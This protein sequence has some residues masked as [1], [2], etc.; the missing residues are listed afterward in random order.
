MGKPFANE[1]KQIPRSLKWAGEIDIS[2][3]AKFI[4]QAL[5]HPLIAIGAGG[6]FTIAEFTRLLHEERGGIGL[7]F[8]P[9]SFIQSK[10]DIRSGCVIIFTASGNNRDV[11][12]TYEA[13]VKREPQSILIVCGKKQ[14]KVEAKAQYHE[15][16]TVFAHTLPA[17]RDGYLATNSLMAFSVLVLRAFGYPAP[18]MEQVLNHGDNTWQQ[19]TINTLPAVPSY[20]LALFGDWGR[21]AATDFE[22]KF[23]EAGLGGVMLADY[24]HFAHGRHNW[25]DKRGDQSTIV[26]FLT[27][28]TDDLAKRTL[29]L[30]PA[31]TRII[32]L[33][34]QISGPIATLVLLLEI[35]RFTLQVGQNMGIDPGRP[36]VPSYGSKIYHLG[37]NPRLKRAASNI[38]SSAID[39]KLAVRGTIRNQTDEIAVSKA[40][41]SYI[42]K[43]AAVRFGALVADFDGTVVPPGI[44]LGRQ[45]SDSVV[46]FFEKLLCT[47]AQLY[48]ATGRGDSIHSIV[49]DSIN[50][51]YHS[52]IYIS[53][54]NGS[55][56]ASLT[57][58]P[59]KA[60]GGPHHHEFEMLLRQFRR[61]PLLADITSIENKS[62]QL[63]VRS[64]AQT[65]SSTISTIIRELVMQKTN[66]KFKVV[67]STHSL[68]II[69][70]TS[71]KLICVKL[72]KTRISDDLEVI[73]IGDCGA[74]FGN[75]YELL[76]HPF[77]LSVDSVSADLQSCWNLLPPGCRNMAGLLHYSKSIAYKTKSFSINI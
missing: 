49:A 41:K 21:P 73:A 57:E 67:Q 77:S 18:S 35:F 4:I 74:F 32:K 38:L 22:S 20:Y 1:L 54:Y 42:A 11:I 63:T 16:T 12:A 19:W 39:R 71:T 47:G 7:A 52:Q 72:A 75:D 40:G 8:T 56:T 10:T 51:K 76:T 6:S 66:G 31:S 34:T 23:S 46:I 65:N 45:L 26:A 58:T 27:P 29:A 30:L 33:E 64:S 68:D 55:V 37:P 59:P 28:E 60:Q 69:P 50:R 44:G 13:A 14:S 48:F 62:F 17:G 15:R 24:R 61:E 70:F 43:L 25:I 36:R 9:L 3:V 53:Y 5:G 2:I